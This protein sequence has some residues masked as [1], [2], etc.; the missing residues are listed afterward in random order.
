MSDGYLDEHLDEHPFALLQP[1][2]A[3]Y[4]CYMH[5][6]IQSP[7]YPL[8]PLHTIAVPSLA[9]RQ[10]PGP[11]PIESSRWLRCA[12]A[13][14]RCCVLH[15]PWPRLHCF[16]YYYPRPPSPADAWRWEGYATAWSV[17]LGLVS[18]PLR[19]ACSF[20]FFFF[21]AVLILI[22]LIFA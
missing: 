7:S 13:S 16:C 9:F 20:F 11:N 18:Y 10:S 15:Q 21:A 14:G 1:P 3:H 8:F 12:I 5:Q 19:C 4:C 22:I 2:T 17:A 6:C